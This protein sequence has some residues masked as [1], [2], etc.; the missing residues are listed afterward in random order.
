MDEIVIARK[1]TSMRQSVEWGI[2]AFQ[3]SFPRVKDWILFEYKRQHK[4]MM[5]LMLLLFNLHAWRVSINQF[6]CLYGIIDTGCQ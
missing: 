1:V 2:C 5:K 6:K 3:A 4:L